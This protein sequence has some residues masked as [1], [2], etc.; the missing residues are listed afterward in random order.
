MPEDMQIEVFWDF[1]PIYDC[2][3]ESHDDLDK[4]SVKNYCSVFWTYQTL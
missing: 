2:Y 1:S 4:E 3:G